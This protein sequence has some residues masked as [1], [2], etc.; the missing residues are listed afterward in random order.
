MHFIYTNKDGTVGTE[1]ALPLR[2]RRLEDGAEFLI[3]GVLRTDSATAFAGRWLGLDVDGQQFFVPDPNADLADL[4]TD[5][6]PGHKLIHA[7]FERDILGKMKDDRKMEVVSYREIK[8]AEK[9]ENYDFRFAWKDTGNGIVEDIEVCRKLTRDRLRKEREPL[10]ADLD[11]EALR[12]IEGGD[13]GK[14][15]DVSREKQRLRDITAMPEI[16]A[17]K[18]PGDLRAIRIHTQSG[19]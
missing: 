1:S 3:E 2:I 6:F 9:P 4:E 10:L 8:K 17:A 18:T 13:K 16:D 11:I 5:H 12:A 14:Q 15:A 7:N 19:N